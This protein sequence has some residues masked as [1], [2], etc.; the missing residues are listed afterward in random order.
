VAVLESLRVTDE[1]RSMLMANR[2]LSDVIELAAQ[3]G[4][5]VPFPHYVSFMMEQR[6]IG[7]AEA[8]LSV[9]L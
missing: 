9:A 3:T 8:L 4:A 5:L 7:P 6:F 2:P 1:I